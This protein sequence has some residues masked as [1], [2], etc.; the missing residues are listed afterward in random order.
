MSE[1]VMNESGTQSDDKEMKIDLD[2]V[3]AARLP[4]GRK[5][6]PRFVVNWLKRTIC[7][8]KLNEMLRI[9]RG[10]RGADFC[11]GVL[12]HL[13]ISV[14]V[15]NAE[16]LPPPEHK[17]ITIVSNHPLGG[18]DGMALIDWATRRWG[19]GVKFVVNDLL[20]AIEPLRDVFVPINK[21]G[22]QG[23]DALD[24]L[25]KAFAA[26]AP[27]I[28]FPAGLVSR[29]GKDGTIAD[30]EWQK[31]F[32]N[33]SIKFNRDIVPVHFDGQNSSFFYKFARRRTRLGLKFNI[34]MIYLPR[35]VFRSE[36]SHYTISVGK[37]IPVADLKGGKLAA[38]TAARIKQTVYSLATPQPK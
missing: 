1:T 26:D 27:V 31:M 22:A 33:K 10:K 35:E 36:G 20:M 32:V 11:R 6:I 13:N 4:R 19:K 17:R 9:N 23:R 38:L 24:R 8:D 16:L 21:H 25:D 12:N 29:R 3:L 7:Q 14:S 28:V 2:A 34:E 30:L 15:A 18:L 37:L 5:L